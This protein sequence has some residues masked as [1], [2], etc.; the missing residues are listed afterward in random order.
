MLIIDIDGQSV[1]INGNPNDSYFRAA[2]EQVHGFA[3]LKKIA[4]GLPAGSTIFDVGANIG[5][6]AITMAAV[7]PQCNIVCFEPS[8]TNFP[9]LKENVKRF[10]SGKITI[11]QIAASNNKQKL[12]LFDGSGAENW[13]GG[14]S[15]IVGENHSD[16]N[17][18][19]KE[20]DAIRLDD[21]GGSLPAFI[22]IDVEGHEPEVLAGAKQ[23]IETARPLIYVEFNTWTLN[24]YGG[25]SPAAFA[26][27]LFEAFEVEGYINA[28]ALLHATL[29][30][31]G[32]A[33]LVLRLKVGKLVPSL[34]RM[35]YPPSALADLAAVS[36]PKGS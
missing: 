22:K 28:G 34:A 27:A 24:A 25:H 7:A 13:S 19:V 32:L 11:H 18:P 10:G 6:S 1:E 20:I 23:I 31:R 33:D 5:L 29:C 30:E 15:H 4:K 35:S 26:T 16:R 3:A 14:W 8:P 21:F 9:Y 12:H 17:W 2:Q 36:R